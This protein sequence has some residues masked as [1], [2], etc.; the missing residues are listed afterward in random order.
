MVDLQDV[1]Y[2]TGTNRSPNN[3]D[4]V[5]AELEGYIGEDPPVTQRNGLA[6]LLR[7]I[8]D[9]YGWGAV[10]DRSRFKGH[11]E[12][13]STKSDP[14]VF[15]Y[16]DVLARANRHTRF[17]QSSI[18]R[19]PF[20]LRSDIDTEAA[21]VLN[22]AASESRKEVR[23]VYITAAGVMSARQRAAGLLFQQPLDLVT[24]ALAH[25]DKVQGGQDVFLAYMMAA[26]ELY[27]SAEPTPQTNVA[28]AL[29]DFDTGVWNDAE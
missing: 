4:S 1:A 22:A 20:D 14:G 2:H 10:I 11:S 13:L 21:T 16:E 29:F 19:P 6:K 8:A 25:N 24:A 15:P 17:A 28:G 12:I 26:E 23:E 18:F 9:Q 27:K 5:G 3:W 7:M